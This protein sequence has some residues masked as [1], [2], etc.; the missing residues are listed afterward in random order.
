MRRYIERN[1]EDLIANSIIESYPNKLIGVHLDVA[2][3]KITIK[4][5]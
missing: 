2:D 1:V 4:T 5:I 3:D